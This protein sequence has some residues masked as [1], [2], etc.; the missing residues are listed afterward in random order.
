MEFKFEYKAYEKVNKD[1][2]KIERKIKW[3]KV[4]NDLYSATV[5]TDIDQ[6]QSQLINNEWALD[7]VIS[8]TPQVMKNA[9]I[10]SSAAKTN[11]NAKP[12]VKI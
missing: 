6:L 5:Q 7:N 8:K 3:E 1:V 12:K 10:L 11:Y 4:D 9:A 2:Q